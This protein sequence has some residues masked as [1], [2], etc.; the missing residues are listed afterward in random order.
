MGRND[1]VR[2]DGSIDYDY[3]GENIDG[4][5][6]Q[7]ADIVV[8]PEL[9]GAI[10]D[11]ETDD[12]QAF[13]DM[14]STAIEKGYNII[15]NK[16]YKITS[17]LTIDLT[18]RQTHM[19][20]I[21]NGWI[22]PSGSGFLFKN[23]SGKIQINLRDGG[24]FTGNNFGVKIEKVSADINITGVHY[25]GIVFVNDGTNQDNNSSHG[26][27]V[28]V[29]AYNG[30][31][32]CLEH[33]QNIDNNKYSDWFGNYKEIFDFDSLN[34]ST[35]NNARDITIK[36]YENHFFDGTH[37]KDSLSFFNCGAIH[38][39]NVALGGKANFL[40][41]I[42]AG[43]TI[44]INK[45]YTVNE[46]IP[47]EERLTKALNI[48]KKAYCFINF[49]RDSS[50]KDVLTVDRSSGGWVF[51][52]KIIGNDLQSNMI[53][54]NGINLQRD[55]FTSYNGVD[56]SSLSIGAHGP[57]TDNFIRFLS[58]ANNYNT[59]YQIG[60]NK[61]D[62]SFRIEMFNLINNSYI[63][64]AFKTDINGNT[65]LGMSGKALGFYGNYGS[66]QMTSAPN[67]TDLASVITLANNLKTILTT[68]GLI[69]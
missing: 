48:E 55:V 52:P 50:C 31:Y 9:Y 25:G 21:V 16:K 68:L 64:A 45:L 2:T 42:K 13:L 58:L 65:G 1:I 10:G 26:C 8:Q 12:T 28:N 43:T 47:S 60:E 44:D 22:T 49:L 54:E 14:I 33:G 57:N 29:E 24:D 20:F 5:N 69:K 32:Q 15:C 59:H 30:C 23:Y 11:G 34:G 63:G 38:A 62:N 67:A 61:D 35:F 27:K 19:A 36:H 51:I 41:N 3:L 66:T 18:N 17:Q 56:T 39:D 46:D 53:I 7:M 40:L 6:S 37:S 4:L